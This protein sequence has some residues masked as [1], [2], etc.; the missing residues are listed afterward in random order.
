MKRFAFITARSGSKGLPDKNIIDLCGKPLMAW[1][2]EAG[3]QSE[4]F[5]HVIVSTDS[6]HYADI[7]RTYGAEVMMRSEELSSDSAPHFVVLKDMINRIPED[8]DYFVL[9]QPTSPLRKA[10]H[11]KEACKLFDE[12]IERFDFLTSVIRASHPSVLVR[13][14]DDDMSMKNFDIDYSQYRRQ[15]YRDYS[16]NGAIFLAK[17]DAYLRQG[18]F[19]GPRC[20]AYEMN[21]MDSVDIDNR[22]DLEL[23]RLIIENEWNK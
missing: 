17:P 18:H 6:E 1:S 8:F 3:L 22:L 14:I 7:A 2:I 9:L 19:Y 12:N 16:P 10:Q 11:L 5:D 20:I 21:A 23:A 13:E 4:V 15:N